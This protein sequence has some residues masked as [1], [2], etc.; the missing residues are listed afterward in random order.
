M[1][2]KVGDKLESI[3]GPCE[4]VS[5]IKDDEHGDMFRLKI[6]NDQTIG[7]YFVV[8]DDG[9]LLDGVYPIV[10][11]PETGSPPK[12]GERPKWKPKKPTWCW[13]WNEENLYTSR[14]VIGYD[15]VTDEQHPYIA[16]R[17]FAETPAGEGIDRWAHAEPCNPP[18]WWPE[19]WR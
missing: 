12:L 7:S 14:L 19:E 2:F 6:L 15:D 17:V 5:A 3:Y 9:A 1:T 10:W 13:V 16:V 8:K 11:F 18:Y 4:V